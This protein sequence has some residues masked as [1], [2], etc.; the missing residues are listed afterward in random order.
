MHG[1]E[2]VEEM[3]GLH[4]QQDCLAQEAD[5]AE[6]ERDQ[7]FNWIDDLV[8][9]RAYVRDELW[10]LEQDLKSK[11]EELEQLK[12]KASGLSKAVLVVTSSVP[13]L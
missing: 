5:K 3:R 13:G 9:Q 11:R 10:R 6:K 7:I 4:H 1:E 12:V 2:L 8:D